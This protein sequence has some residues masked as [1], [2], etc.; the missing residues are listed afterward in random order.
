MRLLSNASVMKPVKYWSRM[1]FIQEIKIPKTTINIS[2]ISKCS[3]VPEEWDQHLSGPVQYVAPKVITPTDKPIKVDEQQIL[4]QKSRHKRHKS[5]GRISLDESHRSDPEQNRSH[6][7]VG[8]R[9]KYRPLEIKTIQPISRQEEMK[10][11]GRDPSEHDMSSHRQMKKIYKDLL[12][13]VYLK[14]EL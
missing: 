3:T 10:R 4:H 14:E 2:D 5:E 6:P 11:F 8:I 12:H 7:S 13:W 9:H 1:L